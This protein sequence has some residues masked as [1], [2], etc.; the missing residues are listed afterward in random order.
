MVQWLRIRLATQEILTQSPAQE[1]PRGLRARNPGLRNSLARGLEALK[2]V[3][4]S[5]HSPERAAAA[6]EARALREK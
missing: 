5:P 6:R 2:P 4:W 1:G 3:S